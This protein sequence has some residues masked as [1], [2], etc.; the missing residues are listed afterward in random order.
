MKYDEIAGRALK[1]YEYMLDPKVPLSDK[2]KLFTAYA[3][4]WNP[5]VD[6]LKNSPE[7]EIDKFWDWFSGRADEIERSI[8]S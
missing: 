5:V 6:Y 3:E 2:E 4:A 7:K 8:A 1:A